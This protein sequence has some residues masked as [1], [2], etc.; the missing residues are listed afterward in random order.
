MSLLVSRDFT[1]YISLNADDGQIY[2]VAY[3]NQKTTKLKNENNKPK[4]ENTQLENRNTWNPKT[5][6]HN[7]KTNKPETENLTR[8]KHRDTQRQFSENICS[9]DDLRSRI[10]GKF[11]EYFLLACLS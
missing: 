1:K 10:F 4:T 2:T 3:R 9:D 7:T 8:K 6:T 5:A 11:L